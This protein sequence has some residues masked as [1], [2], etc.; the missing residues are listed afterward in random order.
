MTGVAIIE[1]DP[2]TL[3]GFTRVIEGAADLVL[4]CAAGSVE[5]F[6]SRVGE[7]PGVVILDLRLRG[8][9]IDGTAAI[10]HLVAAG[11]TLL[12][13]SMFAEEMPVVD[14]IA[15]GAHGYLTKETEPDE[16]VR[17]VRTVGGGRTYFSATVAGF[18]LK[19][20]VQLTPRERDVLR[21]VAAGETTRDIAKELFIGETT[22]NGHLEKIRD[23]TGCRRRADLTR[24]AIK[25]GILSLFG[26]GK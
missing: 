22:V 26:R 14:A 16:I 20:G 4:L 8:G 7:R 6:E 13:V 25:K 5:E 21:L 9:G 2:V 12:I 19:D 17:A 1:D 3:L 23:K 15:A 11:Y 24:F 18:L 10:E